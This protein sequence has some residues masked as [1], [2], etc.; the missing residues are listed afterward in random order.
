[1]INSEPVPGGRSQGSL[2]W[3]GLHNTYFW[4]DRDRGICGVFLTQLLPFFDEEAV[5][6][7]RQFELGVYSLLDGARE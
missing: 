7:F 1:M 2:A 5:A 6:S 3:A 4:I